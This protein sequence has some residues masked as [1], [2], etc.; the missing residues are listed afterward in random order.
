MRKRRGFTLIE[1]LVAMAVFAVAAMAVLNA[2]GQ[3]VN[4]LGALEEKTFA[5]MV[6]D[7]QLALFV[8]DDKPISSAKNGKSEMAGREWFWTIKPIATS[9]NLLRA[10]DVIVWADERRQGSLVSVRTYVP[11][12]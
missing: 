9:D 3:H 4:S 1:V 10:V 11:A 6:A 5:S 12:N 2:T 8:L 7:N